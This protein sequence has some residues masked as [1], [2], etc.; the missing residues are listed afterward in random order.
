MHGDRQHDRF[1][2]GNRDR[3]EAADVLDNRCFPFLRAIGSELDCIC[4]S[5]IN[6]YHPAEVFRHCARQAKSRAACAE[7]SGCCSSDTLPVPR[8]IC[9]QGQWPTLTFCSLT[10]PVAEHF[11]AVDRPLA[12][13]AITLPGVVCIAKAVVSCWEADVTS[14][15]RPFWKYT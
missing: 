6:I 10:L 3:T 15:A 7:P 4:I 9:A 13:F 2:P 11:G 12:C 1:T 8:L 5:M 14:H